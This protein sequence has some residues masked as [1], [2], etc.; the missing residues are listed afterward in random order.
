MIIRSK[1]QMSNRKSK[2]ICNPLTVYMVVSFLT[3][4][5]LLVRILV[6]HGTFLEHFFFYDTRDSLMDFFHSIEYTNGRAP[7]EKY[8][9]LYPPLANFM[10]WIIFRCI[11]TDVSDYWAQ[12][13]T[14]SI[15]MRA[16]YYDLRTF[17]APMLL[18]LI[19]FVVCIV[20]TTCII[21]KIYSEYLLRY[22]VAGGLFFFFSY[23]FL[24]AIE[25]GNIIL[26]VF[27][28]VLFYLLYYDCD[29]AWI[30]MVSLLSLALAVGLKI[31]PGIFFF[32]LLRE[33]RYKDFLCGIF[34]SA[35]SV[36]IPMFAFKEG[37]EGFI[38]WI[39]V[40]FSHTTME[41]SV[42]WVGNGLSCI[43]VNIHNRLQQLFGIDIVTSWSGVASVLICVL[44]VAVSL[45]VD[46]KWKAV[47]ALILGQTLLSNQGEYIY[48]FFSIALLFFMI[49]EKVFTK[50]NVIPYVA[51]LVIVLPIPLAYRFAESYPA[52]N[53]RQASLLVLLGW[54]IIS[55]LI[56]RRKKKNS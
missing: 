47:L 51:V 32:L 49:E 24:M 25:R 54:C 56:T 9:T 13:F 50:K 28:L 46:K 40:M 19:Y 20:F 37:I 26:L 43:I 6:S 23:G 4:L 11:P 27:P 7:Y 17:Q 53:M 15:K 31:Y 36:V 42:P 55:T 48:I 3:L 44:L 38:I 41:S 18:F 8:D 52:N 12:D 21:T 45:V 10:F 30:R 22:Q 5:L 1:L 33:K 39:K 16:T 35:L 34:Y 14:S 29:S 2:V